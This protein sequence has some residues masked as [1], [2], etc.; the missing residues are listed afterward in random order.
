MKD[1]QNIRVVDLQ[2]SIAE[3]YKNLYTTLW[4]RE[5]MQALE[6]QKSEDVEMCGANRFVMQRDRG[7]KIWLKC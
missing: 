6:I 5:Q 3:I 1:L 4:I 7:T 2:G